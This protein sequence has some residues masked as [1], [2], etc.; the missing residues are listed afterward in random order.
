MAERVNSFLICF[1]FLVTLGVLCNSAF[2]TTADA[3]DVK[4]MED[5]GRGVPNR[6]FT[7]PNLK[8]AFSRACKIAM[9]GNIT[10]CSFAWTA[11]K[12]AF[13]FKDPNAVTLEDY[14]TY[15]DVLPVISPANT[16]VYWS[17][18][19]IRNVLEEIAEQPKISSSVNQVSSRIIN[20]MIKDDN[21]LCWCGN[22]TAFL[23]TVN[24]CPITPV[25][26]FWKAFSTHFGESGLGIVYFIADGNRKTGAYQNIS[27]FANFEF[28]NLISDRINRLVV[29][30]V[31]D[32][33]NNMVEKCGNGT[34]KV[35]EDQ[36]VSKY[37][38]NMSYSCETVCGNASNIHN[39][40]VL[41]KQTLKIIREKRSKG[42]T[43]IVRAIR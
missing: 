35:L 31:Y 26:A 17:G 4:M 20:L 30:D 9:N 38:G 19:N 29:I 18:M 7:P 13:G 37:G 25:V 11:F 34:L 21:V 40:S 42:I 3:Q 15:F 39:I 24:P 14:N 5:M 1:F 43:S 6:C 2:Y 27:F 23:D 36:A 41:A 16:A 22:A 10:Q 12:F 33:D 28:P 8:S 32:C